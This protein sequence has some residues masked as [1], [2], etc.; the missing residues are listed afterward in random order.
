MRAPSIASP[1]D[2]PRALVIG[3]EAG[4]RLIEHMLAEDFDVVIATDGI[5]ALDT[6]PLGEIDL[7]VLDAG[8]SRTGDPAIRVIRAREELAGVPILVVFD[9]DQDAWSARLLQEGAQDRVR[10]PVSAEELR[11]RARTL[12]AI[13]RVRDVLGAAVAKPDGDLESLARQVAAEKRLAED[14]CRKAEASNRAKDDFLA[15]LAHELRTPLNAVLG[16]TSLLR[17]EGV[18][19]G[20]LKRGLEVIDRNARVQARLIED[21][22]E[23]SAMILH[24][25]QVRLDPIAFGPVLSEALDAVRPTA[26]AKG[27]DLRCEWAAR[28]LMVLGDAERLLQVLHNLLGNAVKFTPGGGAVTVRMCV[29][30]GAVVL[31]VADTGIGIAPDLLPHIF[32]QFTQ[33][34][35]RAPDRSRGLGLG[36][37]IAHHLIELHGGGIEAASP[38]EGRGTTFTVRLPVLK[39]P[40]PAPAEH[41]R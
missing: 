15:V 16:W 41:A 10:M 26:E 35:G 34:A 21:V 32:D 3:S 31:E 37:A 29:A 40:Q 6:V 14:A 4:R 39:S 22:L 2:R 1:V 38:G 7:V 9:P 13:K 17:R 33:G 20:D 27:I 18:A 23:V 19:E 12:V 5:A 25:V 11:G 28:D 30:E 36:L 24:K 8:A